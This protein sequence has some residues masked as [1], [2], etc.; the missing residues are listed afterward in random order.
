[1]RERLE[2]AA[3]LEVE[4]ETGRQHQVRLHLSHIG[5]PVIGDRVYRGEGARSVVNAARQMLHAEVLA[6]VH[7]VTGQSIRAVSPLPDDFR[8]LLARLR[9]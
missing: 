1:V 3:L 8:R 2:G 4:L 6:F 9:G 5:L 7:P